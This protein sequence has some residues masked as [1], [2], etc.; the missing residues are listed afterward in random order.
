MTCLW[1]IIDKS[2]YCYFLYQCVIMW[3]VETL[4][5]GV[6]NTIFVHLIIKKTMAAVDQ[7]QYMHACQ[8]IPPSHHKIYTHFLDKASQENCVICIQMW[9]H[10]CWLPNS[11]SCCLCVIYKRKTPR[12]EI[13][14]YTA[15]RLSMQNTQRAMVDNWPCVVTQRQC[16]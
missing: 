4:L 5:V 16:C 9:Y 11:I 1:Q 10:K 3:T 14:K 6:A 8:P 7:L 15:V 2:R 13:K 12:I